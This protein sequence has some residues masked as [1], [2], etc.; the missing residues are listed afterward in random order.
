VTT[1]K[2]KT[3]IT[4]KRDG[5]LRLFIHAATP[6]ANTWVERNAPTYG[7]LIRESAYSFTLFFNRNYDAG[8]V[9]AYIASM[10]E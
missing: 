6:D 5:D 2:A 9:A 3:E 4:V 8:E 10:G 7:E 1:P